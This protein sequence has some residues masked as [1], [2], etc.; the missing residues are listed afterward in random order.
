MAERCYLCPKNCGVD[1]EK[2]K[3]FC[4]SS[5]VIRLSRVG[6]HMWEEPCI[7]HKNGSGTVFF[8]GCNMGCVYCQNHE[9]SSGLKGTDVHV[10]T[11]CDEILRLEQLGA[12]N[13]NFVTPTHYAHK[14]LSVLDKVKPKLSIPIVYNTSGY[15]KLETLKMLDGYID[16]YLPDLKYYSPEISGKYSCCPDYFSV[17]LQAVKEMLSQ[18]SKPVLNNEGKMLKGTLVRHLVLPSLYKDSIAIFDALEKSIDTSMAA[19]SIMCQYF[20][21]YKAEQHPEINRKTTTLE[22]MYVVERV[23]KMNFALGFIQDKSSAVE[24]YVPEFDYQR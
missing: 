22:Y 15:E 5:D 17:A 20:P 24:E 8:A 21:S 18:T 6:L 19:V 14:I 3:G 12:E 23:R 7:S 11:L 16:I 4:K 2:Q 1:R 13:I 9:I 10:S